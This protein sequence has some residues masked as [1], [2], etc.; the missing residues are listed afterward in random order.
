VVAAAVIV[1]LLVGTINNYLHRR[2][3]MVHEH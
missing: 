2:W 3:E 1:A